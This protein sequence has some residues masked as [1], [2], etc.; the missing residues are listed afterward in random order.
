MSLLAAMTK[1]VAGAYREACTVAAAS[2]Q[3]APDYGSFVRGFVAGAV[4][5]AK[6][7]MLFNR[8]RPER[9]TRRENVIPIREG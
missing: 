6:Q 9:E 5:A 4:A 1:D 7:A 3:P 8:R 2:G